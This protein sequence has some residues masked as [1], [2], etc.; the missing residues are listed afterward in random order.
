VHL[1]GDSEEARQAGIEKCLNKPVRHA[2]LHNC[3][4]AIAQGV[5]ERQA[6]RRLTRAQLGLSAP[7]QRGHVLLVED[8]PVNQEVAYEM[9]SWLGCQVDVANNGQEAIAAFE[10]CTY[11]LILMDVQM[12]EMDGLEATH[13][14]RQREAQNNRPHTTIV[15]LTAHALDSDREQYLAAGMD[16]YLSKPFTVDQ[17]QGA[18]N[19]WLPQAA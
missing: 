1:A 8:N 10:R 6:S 2:Q 12:P 4:V 14:I 16:G 5:S 17:L 3:L 18:L 7:G 15:A 9:L 13:N 19:R 11:D